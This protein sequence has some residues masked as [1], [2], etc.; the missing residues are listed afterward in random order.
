MHA[1]GNMKKYACHGNMRKYACHRDIR[2]C[3]C[4]RQHEK[5]VYP[6]EKLE[7]ILIPLKKPVAGIMYI[8][9]E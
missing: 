6:W 2:K 9:T 5:Y 8:N 4:R 3:A 7:T 1:T